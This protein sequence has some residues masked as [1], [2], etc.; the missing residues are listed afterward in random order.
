M[1]CQ[2]NIG[3]YFDTDK[4]EIIDWDKRYLCNQ[5]AIYM[6]KPKIIQNVKVYFCQNH[7]EHFEKFK[8]LI[9]NYNEK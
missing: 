4:E 2:I 3:F 1:N 6:W 8:G 5:K 7:L 9:E